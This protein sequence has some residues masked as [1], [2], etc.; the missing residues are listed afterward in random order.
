[1]HSYIIPLSL[2][3]PLTHFKLHH[4]HLPF[5]FHYVKHTHS[6]IPFC[7]QIYSDDDERVR[8]RKYMNVEIDADQIQLNKHFTFSHPS[9]KN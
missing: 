1:M 3:P 8:E 4:H 6:N 5:L 2:S 9:E 7:R